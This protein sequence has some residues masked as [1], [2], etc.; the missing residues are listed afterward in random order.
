VTNS[1]KIIRE[2]NR[3]KVLSVKHVQYQV[4]RAQITTKEDEKAFD[5]SMK[6]K[7]HFLTSAYQQSVDHARGADHGH[8]YHDHQ[9]PQRQAGLAHLRGSQPSASQHDVSVDFGS[10]KSN[11]SPLRHGQI[12][13]QDATDAESVSE[14]SRQRILAQERLGRGPEVRQAQLDA[15]ARQGNPYVHDHMSSNVLASH[16]E[17]NRYMISD[18]ERLA[19]KSMHNLSRRAIERIQAKN[20]MHQR[21]IPDMRPNAARS[22]VL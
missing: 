17:S 8:P 4:A 18:P 22:T 7:A 11:D 1:S 2:I 13:G 19:E 3:V 16:D 9:S 15:D 12:N 5:E 21:Q 10:F 20:M 14:R 6:T